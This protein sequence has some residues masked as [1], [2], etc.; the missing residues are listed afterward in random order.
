MISLF[1]SSIQV[2]R[3]T[4][5]KSTKCKILIPED[6]LIS[7]LKNMPKIKSPGNDGL[8]KEFMKNFEMN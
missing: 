7:A 5:E 2:P 3:L 8:R 4:E 1:L 6:E